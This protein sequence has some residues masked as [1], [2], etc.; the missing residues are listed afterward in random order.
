MP[1]LFRSGSSTVVVLSSNQSETTT[2]NETRNVHRN[3]VCVCV[4]VS[5]KQEKQRRRQDKG[6]SE[7]AGVSPYHLFI[8]RCGPKLLVMLGTDTGPAALGR[9][10][11]DFDAE[12]SKRDGN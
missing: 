6:T 7:H 11:R 9:P 12:A 8:P 1:I 4:C 2:R 3:C 5:S 10:Q